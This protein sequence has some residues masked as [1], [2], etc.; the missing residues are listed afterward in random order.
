MTTAE[1]AP[2]SQVDPGQVAR[3]SR[4]RLLPEHIAN[5]PASVEYMM[6]IGESLGIPPVSAFQHIYVF[7]DKKTGRLKAGM[8]AHLMHA[9][10]VTA[11]HELHVEG[12]AV[13]ATAVLIRRT[14]QEKLDRFR[15]M[16]EEERRGKLALLEDTERLYRIER[17]QLSDRIA[18]LRE[19]KEVGGEG[20][21]GGLQ[22]E[23]ER[24]IE[25]LRQQLR[26][27]PK[28]YDFDGLR[29]RVSETKFDLAALTRFES[30]W[31]MARATKVGLADKGVWRDF[32]PEMLK[33]R[34]KVTVV[35]DGAV[36]VIL[37]IRR[38]FHDLG[39]EF[40]GNVDDDLAISNVIYT[41]EEL[42]AE[43]DGDGHPIEGRVVN[44]TAPGVS[45][46]QDLLVHKARRIISGR[47]AEEIKAAVEQTL[48]NAR[49]SGE[50]K[51]S[52]IDSIAKAVNEAGRGEEEVSWEE[53]S[54]PLSGYLDAVI[55]ANGNSSND[56]NH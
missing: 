16:R 23:I 12:N 24:E 33:N 15:M 26:D 31:T 40:S 14:T 32:G 52:R 43:V 35:R 6:R 30:T 1:L 10:A 53:G 25:D 37:G 39:L 45:R 9:L 13:Q 44:V 2:T 46:T 18:D 3:I 21:K 29:E 41:A 28:K 17:Q 42:G 20:I 38:I 11:G 54:V 19:L 22:E 7:E 55:H 49:I 4:S 48:K 8:S 34:A 27:L 36:D 47:S 51:A 50:E 5:D 56:S